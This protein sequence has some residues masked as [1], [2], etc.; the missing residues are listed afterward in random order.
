MSI[1]PSDPVKLYGRLLGEKDSIP[2]AGLL[3]RLDETARLTCVFILHGQLL[4]GW[5]TQAEGVILCKHTH[6]RDLGAS[7]TVYSA[8][9][10]GHSESIAT[11]YGEISLMRQHMNPGI[12]NRTDRGKQLGLYT[13]YTGAISAPMKQTQGIFSKANGRTNEASRVWDGLRQHGLLLQGSAEPRNLTRAEVSAVER[14]IYHA[15]TEMRGNAVGRAL[16]ITIS[17]N[18]AEA[19]IIPH[20]AGNYPDILLTRTVLDLGTVI[21]VAPT[22]QEGLRHQSVNPAL[23]LPAFELLETVRDSD[24]MLEYLEALCTMPSPEG[25]IVRPDAIEY[26]E[27]ISMKANERGPRFGWVAPRD[28]K[29]DIDNQYWRQG[30]ATTLQP[31]DYLGQESPGKLGK[32]A[33]GMLER[34]EE[35]V[36]LPR[37]NSRRAISTAANMTLLPPLT[38]EEQ[39]ALDEAFEDLD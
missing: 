32:F 29:A 10:W 8:G 7:T 13:Y 22:V 31:E 3:T 25:R 19:L 36:P 18:M 4:Q 39:Q 11:H 23:R 20:S 16:N 27:E 38:A 6:P 33:Q 17:P 35:E 12:L 2:G 14:S 15:I 1:Q 37:H 5:L 30:P 34:A 28:I 26:L 24:L 21:W 9:Y